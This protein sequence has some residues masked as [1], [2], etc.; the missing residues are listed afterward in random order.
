MVSLAVSRTVILQRHFRSLQVSTSILNRTVSYLAM[1]K[2][3][4]AGSVSGIYSYLLFNLYSTCSCAEP[5]ALQSEQPLGR[6]LCAQ[7]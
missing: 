4:T 2:M 6:K 5:L 3:F 1:S 7:C